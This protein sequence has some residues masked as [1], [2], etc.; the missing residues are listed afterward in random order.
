LLFKVGWIVFFVLVPWCMV[1]Y[2]SSFEFSLCVLVF[3]HSN[4]TFRMSCFWSLFCLW[5][6]L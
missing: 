3:S 1:H 2:F 5:W 6:R 4:F